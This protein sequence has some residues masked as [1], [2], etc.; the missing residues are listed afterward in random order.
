MTTSVVHLEGE[1]MSDRDFRYFG[2]RC[3][4]PEEYAVVYERDVHTRLDLTNTI[5]LY[6]FTHPEEFDG[7]QRCKSCAIFASRAAHTNAGRKELARQRRWARAR[8]EHAT[9][10]RLLG[11]FLYGSEHAM[12]RLQ[13]WREVP[14]KMLEDAFVHCETRAERASFTNA[15]GRATALWIG[16]WCRLITKEIDRRETIARFLHSVTNNQAQSILSDLTDDQ[17]EELNEAIAVELTAV[18]KG[19]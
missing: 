2:P 15:R 1:A 5:N 3:M 13:R 17:R 14:Q 7:R 12:A 6:E 18:K 10:L 16:K 11:T 4:T 9:P 19:A 8:P